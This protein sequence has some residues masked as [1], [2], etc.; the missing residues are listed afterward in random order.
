MPKIN[1][2]YK[3]PH[4][5]RLEGK[6]NYKKRLGLVRG[7]KTRVVIRKSLDNISVQFVDYKKDGDVIKASAASVTLEKLGWKA[8]RGNIPAAYLTGLLAGLRAKKAGVKEAILDL[9]LQRNTK[10]SRLYAALKG[11]LDAGVSVPHDAGILPDE[12]R[13]SGQHIAAYVSSLKDLPKQFAEVKAA[14]MKM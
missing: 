10:G 3:M 6:T 7:G 12:K 5:R 13:I 1:K 4:K 8:A 14:I 11:V 9:G 2:F